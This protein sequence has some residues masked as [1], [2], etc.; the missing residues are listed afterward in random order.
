MSEVTNPFNAEL[1]GEINKSCKEDS[2][3]CYTLMTSDD[4]G[5]I[6]IKNG[7]VRWWT[8]L[9]LKSGC[10]CSGITNYVCWTVC[11]EPNC[12]AQVDLHAEMATKCRLDGDN[13]GSSDDD[14]SDATSTSLCAT[15]LLLVLNV[16]S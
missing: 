10:K 12:N 4:D 11:T 8:G 15:L 5:N 6:I 9:N 2:D 13:G 3:T 14:E 1:L 16:S 7:C